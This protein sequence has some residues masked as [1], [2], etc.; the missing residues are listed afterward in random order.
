MMCGKDSLSEKNREGE[1]TVRSNSFPLNKLFEKWNEVESICVFQSR[2]LQFL[3]I[4][5][6]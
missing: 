3:T 5:S 4:L 1:E 2:R 6:Q